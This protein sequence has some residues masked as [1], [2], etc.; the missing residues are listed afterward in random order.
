MAW[1]ALLTLLLLE[2]TVPLSSLERLKANF[3]LGNLDDA[4]RHAQDCL[5]ADRKRCEPVVKDLLAY[6]KLAHRFD[7]LS[8]DEARQLIALDRR[9]D[10]GGWGKLTLASLARYVKLPLTRAR[11]L[12]GWGEKAKALQEVDAALAID[13]QFD[14]ALRLKAQLLGTDAGRP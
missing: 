2:P 6:R 7:N 5:K 12:L 4:Y 14:E 1:R 9:I 3:V 8:A 11:T 10:A 13:P